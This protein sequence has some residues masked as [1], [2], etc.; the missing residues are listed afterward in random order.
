MKKIGEELVEE[1]DFMREED[2]SSPKTLIA[3]NC[4]FSG[5][6]HVAIRI[7]QKGN[8]YLC[9]NGKA[10][11]LKAF[12]EGRLSQVTCRVCLGLFYKGNK[13]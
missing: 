3:H 12:R 7:P 11:G 9:G 8:K 5:K 13:D 10:K 6:V 1:L 2:S 4:N